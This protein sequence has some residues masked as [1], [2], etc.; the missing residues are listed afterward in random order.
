MSLLVFWANKYWFYKY[1]SYDLAPVAIFKNLAEIKR[2][3]LP[4]PS[5]F[6]LLGGKMKRD[7]RRCKGTCGKVKSK[8]GEK[9]TTEIAVK[10]TEQNARGIGRCK[11][12]GSGGSVF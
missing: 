5:K 10:N 6:F 8:G 9:E 12:D 7:R 1:W 11:W 2:A 3:I 4:L